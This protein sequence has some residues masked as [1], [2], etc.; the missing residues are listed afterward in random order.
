[1]TQR[2]INDY[3]PTE[4]SKIK[5]FIDS[6]ELS[7]FII[8]PKGKIVETGEKIKTVK[9]GITSYECGDTFQDTYIDLKTIEVGVEP[10][11][12]FNKKVFTKLNYKLLKIE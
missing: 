9:Q 6:K 4:T 3:F 12:S 1:M 11:I 2:E 5:V 7:Y 10:S 8:N